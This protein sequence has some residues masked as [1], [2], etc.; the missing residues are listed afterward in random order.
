MGTKT[1]GLREAVHERL[2][3]RKREDESF[4]DLVDRLVAERRT[5][6]RE[7]FG[8]LPDGAAEDLEDAVSAAR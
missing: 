7:G 4:S 3:A 6:W 8:T 5:D 2:K 1:I